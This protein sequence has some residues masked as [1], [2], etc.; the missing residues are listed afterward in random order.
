MMSY[1]SKGKS[2]KI[3][4]KQLYERYSHI[5]K[6]NFLSYARNSAKKTYKNSKGDEY[7]GMDSKSIKR[8]LSAHFG[9][10]E[11]EVIKTSQQRHSQEAGKTERRKA[12]GKRRKPRPYKE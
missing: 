5:G 4:K 8:Q 12:K 10:I 2:D 1:S 9:I 11:K 7:L 6:R 3:F